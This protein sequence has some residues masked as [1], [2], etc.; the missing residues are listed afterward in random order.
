MSRTRLL[1]FVV[2]ASIDPAAAL[3]SLRH[4]LREYDPDLLEKPA[5][6]VVNKLDLIDDEVV[7]LLEEDLTRAGIP[8]FFASATTGS[9]LDRLTDAFFELLPP[10]PEPIAQAGR[11]V[12]AA[13]PP[14]VRR[15]MSGEGWVVTGT[16]VEA[17]VA[18]FDPSNRDAVAYLQHHF[19]AL[20]IDK[21]L[22]RAGASTGDEVHIGQATF[23][24]L[25]EDDPLRADAESMPAEDE[26]AR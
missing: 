13:R 12:P 5:L 14:S 26:S 4:E 19:R 18:R 6:L 7:K 2:D 21:L 9:G 1:A 22:K 8:L 23:D 3:E 25:S 16:E 20:G 15:H 24:Y 10:K 11:T 17:L